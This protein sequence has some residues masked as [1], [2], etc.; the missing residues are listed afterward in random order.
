MGAQKDLTQNVLKRFSL[1]PDCW[2]SL[3]MR[4]GIPTEIQNEFKLGQ[5]MDIT[6]HIVD[7]QRRR[8]IR[9]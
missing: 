1:S 6:D 7:E 2:K 5:Y 4:Y 8:G 9:Q 3:A